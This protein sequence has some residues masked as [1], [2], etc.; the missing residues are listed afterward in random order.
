MFFDISYY[1]G[2]AFIIGFSSNNVF[3]FSVELNGAQLYAFLWI[4]FFKLFVFISI[5]YWPGEVGLEF[6]GT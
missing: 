1:P 4:L 2:P 5:K 3:L 6:F